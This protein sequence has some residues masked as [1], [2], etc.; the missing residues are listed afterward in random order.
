M[1]IKIN[2]YQYLKYSMMERV[3]TVVY[4]A[5]SKAL[6]G[7][8]R[9]SL[10]FWRKLTGELK[11]LGLD[12]NPYDWCVENKTIN[13]KQWTTLWHVDNLNISHVM[14]AVLYH[15]ISN[16][17][18]LLVQEAPLTTIWRAMYN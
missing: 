15:V 5:L 3:K 16:I 17:N 6:Y 9:S 14:D 2:P 10:L 4:A 18:K 7:T 1:L 11:S 8:L 13:G 12:I